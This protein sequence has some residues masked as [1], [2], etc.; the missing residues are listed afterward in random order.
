VIRDDHPMNHFQAVNQI[1]G[2][3]SKEVD[4]V[5]LYVEHARRLRGLGL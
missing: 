5:M 1:G 4:P 2:L 3:V